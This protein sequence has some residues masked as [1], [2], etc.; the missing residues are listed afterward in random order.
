M[1]IICRNNALIDNNRLYFRNKY[2]YFLILNRNTAH[3]LFLEANSKDNH[4]VAMLPFTDY[5]MES[6]STFV[7]ITYR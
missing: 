1:N 2:M 7:E 5:I 6:R 3:I 4:V